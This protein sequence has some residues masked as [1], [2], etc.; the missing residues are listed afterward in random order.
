MSNCE[1]LSKAAVMNALHSGWLG[2]PVHYAARLGSTNTMLREMADEGAAAGTLLITDYQAAGK[3][4]FDR[5]WEAPPGTSLLFSLLFRPGWPARR[6]PW[7]TMC[8]GLAVVE[9]VESETGL[10]AGLKWP[11]DVMLKTGGGWRKL[12]GLLLETELEEDVLK[13]AILGIGLNV[14]IPAEQLPAP[15]ATSLLAARGEATPRLPLLATLLA[16]LE[17]HYEAADRGES[18]QRE[19]DRR[20]IILGQRV[21]V[22]GGRETVEGMAQGT[23]AWGRLLVRDDEGRVH[24]IPAGDVTLREEGGHV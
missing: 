22:S 20:L 10:G 12:G 7:L 2:R 9:A 14:N 15:G 13:L 3:G 4:R 16:R 19:W 6:A 1:G 17:G 18:P 5:R 24:A 11:N 8:A 21:R 23:D